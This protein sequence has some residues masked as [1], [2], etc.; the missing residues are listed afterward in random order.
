MSSLAR[1]LRFAPAGLAATVATHMGWCTLFP[2]SEYA[3]RAHRIAGSPELDEKHPL[4]PMVDEAARAI[5][6]DPRAVRVFVSDS[7]KDPFAYGSLLPAR[8]WR[9]SS[10]CSVVICVPTDFLERPEDFDCISLDDR[11]VD[12]AIAVPSDAERRFVLG[13]ELSHIK[14]EDMLFHTVVSPLAVVGFVR[15][16]ASDAL[17]SG[18]ARTLHTTRAAPLAAAGAVA[19]MVIGA[20]AVSWVQEVAADVEAARAGYAHDGQVTMWRHLQVNKLVREVR[21]TPWITADGDY[22]LDVMHPSLGARMNYLS[23]LEAAE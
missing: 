9:R 22:L 16:S 6:V 21:H 14:H 5:G 1:F 15:L 13:H 8:L 7:T 2:E 12:P 10:D 17:R 11:F 20:V 4:R 19:A 3:L 18:L 23:R